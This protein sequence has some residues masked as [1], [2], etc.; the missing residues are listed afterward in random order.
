MRKKKKQVFYHSNVPVGGGD[1]N[2][3]PTLSIS[4][5]KFQYLPTRL[6][7]L[8][9]KMR[10]ILF[11]YYTRLGRRGE[12]LRGVTAL[13]APPALCFRSVQR[14]P[15]PLMGWAFPSLVPA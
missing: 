9:P 5:I 12:S 8:S 13:V 2:K 3:A 10:E 15:P 1:G 6:K 4:F 14:C 7:H 11:C